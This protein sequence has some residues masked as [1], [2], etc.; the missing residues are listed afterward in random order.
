MSTGENKR[1]L[2]DSPSFPDQNKRQRTDH[3]GDDSDMDVDTD[4]PPHEADFNAQPASVQQAV[5][6]MNGS[7][8]GKVLQVFRTIVQNITSRQD[9]MNS[10]VTNIADDSDVSDVVSSV[11]VVAKL[12]CQLQK[13]LDSTAG[14]YQYTE[15]LKCLAE[16][17][18]SCGPHLEIP[19][20]EYQKITVQ[21]LM[22][23]CCPEFGRDSEVLRNLLNQLDGVPTF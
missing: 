21:E 10:K 2:P 12:K 8:K 1:M 13:F 18:N 20:R 6:L 15:S 4:N 17:I 14:T 7:A 19:M 23:V 5:P 16:E 11:V 22:E 9:E 3:D